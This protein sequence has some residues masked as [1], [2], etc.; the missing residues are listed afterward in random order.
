[1]GRR[2]RSEPGAW[3]RNELP[4]RR[5]VVS[6][7]IFRPAPHLLATLRELRAARGDDDEITQTYDAF[8]LD[9]GLGPP[10]YLASDG[11]I[12]WDD[13]I[14]GVKGTLREALAAIRAGVRKTGLAEL[15]ELL[16][17]R[18]SESVG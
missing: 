5:I 12:V 8:L 18:S 13:D 16:P 10:T 15:L 6:M 1:L 7:R 17:R 3:S 14:W 2:D 4:N 11:R 9:P